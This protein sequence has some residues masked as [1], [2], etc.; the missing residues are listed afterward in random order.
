MC[1]CMGVLVPV[2]AMRLYLMCQA[3]HLALGERARVCRV[4]VCVSVLYKWKL[5]FDDDGGGSSGSR[6]TTS[7]PGGSTSYSALV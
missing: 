6:T 4:H 7:Q 1:V 5:I 3:G 2:A